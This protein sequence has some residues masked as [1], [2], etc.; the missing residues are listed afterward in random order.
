MCRSSASLVCSDLTLASFEIRSSRSYSAFGDVPILRCS[1]STASENS[2]VAKLYS[3]AKRA[4]SSQPLYSFTRRA[5]PSQLLSVG[6][7][8]NGTISNRVLDFTYSELSVKEKL[9][10]PAYA[11]QFRCCAQ[12]TRDFSSTMRWRFDAG[13]RQSGLQTRIG[14]RGLKRRRRWTSGTQP[15]SD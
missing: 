7:S 11:S 3:F 8:L 13:H 2:S 12:N 1:C 15:E 5:S 6:T 10:A 9:F 14:P 4:F